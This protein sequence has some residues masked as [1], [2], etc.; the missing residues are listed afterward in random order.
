MRGLFAYLSVLTFA[1]AS[2]AMSGPVKAAA[3]TSCGPFTFEGELAAPAGMAVRSVTRVTSDCR[4]VHEPVQFLT[5]EQVELLL[6]E[7]FG[8]PNLRSERL[9]GPR[10]TSGKAGLQRP[11]ALLAGGP[12]HMFI[13]VKDGAGLNLTS[14][15]P[16]NFSYGYNGST[17]TSYNHDATLWRAV[18]TDPNQCGPGWSIEWGRTAISISGGG[19]GSSFI[20]S[21]VHAEFSYLGRFDCT[22]TKYYNVLDTKL[23]GFG[24][25][26]PSTCAYRTTYR[27]VPALGAWY[28]ERLCWDAY[29]WTQ[30]PRF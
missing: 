15:D 14:I 30:P 1:I 17:I 18:D 23:T 21:L 4:V 16:H 9:A 27:E 26:S 11:A 22:G 12:I 3:P 19:I 29:V 10:V 7:P 24:N 8:Q 13:R 28:E 5:R 20:D 6:Q 2:V 25:G